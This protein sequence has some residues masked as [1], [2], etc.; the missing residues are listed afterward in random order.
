[1]NRLVFAGLMPFVCFGIALSDAPIASIVMPFSDATW[2]QGLN[3]NLTAQA[4]QEGVTFHWTFSNGDT[5]EGN[6][7]ALTAPEAGTYTLTMVATNSSGESAPA[8]DRIIYVTDIDGIL[9]QPSVTRVLPLWGEVNPEMTFTVTAEVTDPNDDGPFTYHW[10]WLE[11]GRPVRGE[12]MPLTVSLPAGD[13]DGFSYLLYCTVINQS[14]HPSYPIPASVVVKQGNLAPRSR[15]VVPEGRF[16]SILQGTELSFQAEGADPENDLPLSYRW[17]GLGEGFLFG[18]SVSW[19]FDEPGLFSVI[20]TALDS[21]GNEEPLDVFKAVQ[22]RVY[23]PD[24]IPIP[25]AYILQPRTSTRI[26]RGDPLILTGIAPVETTGAN[27][28]VTDVFS[29]EV[30]ATAEGAAAQRLTIDR[31]GLFELRFRTENLGVLSA[32]NRGNGRWIAVHERDDNRPPVIRHAGAF[33]KLV[34]NGGTVEISVEASDPD[35]DEVQLAWAQE[36]RIVAKGD[37]SR[38]FTFNIPDEAFHGGFFPAAVETLAVDARGKAPD[39]PLI[40]SILVYEDLKPP[41]LGINGL[42]SGS[43]VFVA[44][45]EP[46]QLQPVIDNPDNRELAFYWAAYLSDELFPF[47]EAFERDPAPIMRDQP[48]VASLVFTAQTPDRSAAVTDGHALFIH[49]YD[50]QQRP[51]ARIT[52]PSTDQLA[53]DVGR[54]F[55]LAGQAVEPNFLPAGVT[56]GEFVM[57]ISNTLTWTITGD[58]GFE[59]QITRNQPLTLAL[60][61]PGLYQVALSVENNLGLS[62]AVPDVVTVT[63][64]QPLGD[65]AYEPNNTREQATPISGGSY[66]GVS[67]GADDP[68]DWYRFT[69]VEAG[70]AIEMDFDLS[71]ATT[72]VEIQVYQGDRLVRSELLEPGRRHPFTFAGGGGGDY[73]LRLVAQASG[74]RIGGLSY[75]FSVGELTPRLTFNYIKSDE[76]EETLLTLVNPFGSG[77]DVNLVAHDH[78]GKPLGEFSLVLP[79][80]GHWE[81]AVSSLFSDPLS[82]AWVHVLSDSNIVGLATIIA[83]DELTCM[84]ETAT[85]GS[86]DQLVVPHIAQDTGFWFTRAAIAN[87]SGEVIETSFR[88]VAGDFAIAGVE[89]SNEA[90]LID[91]EAFFQ[92]SLP[93][94]SEWGTFIEHEARPGLSGLELFGTKTGS[95]RLAALNLSSSRFANPNYIYEDRDIYFPHIAKDTRSFW[96]GIA[97]VNTGGDPIDVRLVAYSDQGG[98]LGEEVI[99]MAPFDKQVG[100]AHSFFNQLDEDSQISWIQ[101][102]TTGPVSGYALFGDNGNADRRLAGL[103][104]VRGGSNEVYFQK[105]LHEP[106]MYWTGLAVVNLSASHEANLH[107]VAYDEAGQVVGTADRSIGAYRKDVIPVEALFGGVLPEGARW[108]RLTSDQPLAAFELFGD[109][110]NNFMAGAVAQ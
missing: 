19:T 43:T 55:T 15:I 70:S 95:P 96:T 97:F 42:V 3:Y 85:I 7:V 65:N 56:L 77:A 66:G 108:I 72:T 29:G 17:V 61:E 13:F 26:F 24:E 2:L 51:T 40:H 11:E 59:Q 8:D 100:L 81:K 73:F 23:A 86:L 82:I 75:S 44:V 20:V 68:E 99:A 36:G 110:A 57:P 78:T 1:M 45:G 9:N 38:Q 107:Y 93:A 53:V 89:A 109:I 6:Q 48:G 4:D 91:F 74:K 39:M 58:N 18:A 106:G 67:V 79:G 14:G 104:A 50:P 46:Y 28:F 63:V 98:V 12:G 33:R 30:V 60:D 62:A 64:R 105:I 80:R 37:R 101:C 31:S 54:P 21:N 32:A 47:F 16:I 41:T 27:W 22:I 94:G 90:S 34:K 83:R 10:F 84:A 76:V 92:G 49:F 87:T 71:D 25:E 69:Q 102:R 52:Q 35:G 103:P 5:Y 88:S